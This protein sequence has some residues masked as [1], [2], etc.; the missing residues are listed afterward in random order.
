MAIN[1]A[2]WYWIVAGSTA[3]VWC[4]AAQYAHDG[5]DLSGVA[6]RW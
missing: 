6:H 3:Q 5:G 2:A 4:S 1:P